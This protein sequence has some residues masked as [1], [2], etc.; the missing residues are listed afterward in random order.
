MKFYGHAEEVSQ[1]IVKAFQQPE[2]LP[3]ALAPIFIHRKDD[4]PCRK[5][6]WHK[7]H[8]RALR[9]RR[10]TGLSPMGRC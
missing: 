1:R 5:W 9:H 2:T 4:V 7:R 6:S 3:K 8:Y 10:C